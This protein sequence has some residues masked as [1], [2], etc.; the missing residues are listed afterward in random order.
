MIKSSQAVNSKLSFRK[1]TILKAVLK[2]ALNDMLPNFIVVSV[3]FIFY[4]RDINMCVF[5]LC[6][7]VKFKYAIHLK[8]I[9]G[10][11]SVIR[12]KKKKK[13]CRISTNWFVA[14]S[15]LVMLIQNHRTSSIFLQGTY[16]VLKYI[17]TFWMKICYTKF[18][19]E[20][21]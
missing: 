9:Q 10:C 21:K 19:F 16:T 5:I 14:H 20:L 12:R 11:M 13:K 1:Q 17:I 2:S 15:S 6:M 18:G 8:L 4:V 7:Q 3:T